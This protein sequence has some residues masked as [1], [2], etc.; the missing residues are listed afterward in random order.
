MSNKKEKTKSFTNKKRASVSQSI[1][2]LVESI[3]KVPVSGSGDGS[4]FF[5]LQMMQQQQSL[6]MQLVSSN[7]HLQPNG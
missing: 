7:K 2:K 3:D 4:M 6:Q 1:D 5:S